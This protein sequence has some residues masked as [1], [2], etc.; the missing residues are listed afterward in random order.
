MGIS[1]SGIVPGLSF[2]PGHFNEQ[3]VR[4]VTSEAVC[5]RMK[6]QRTRGTT[7]IC[8]SVLWAVSGKHIY[9]HAC[10]TAKDD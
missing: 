10:K 6:L 2:N 3:F 8:L 4:A 5:D 9:I 1:C 7:A